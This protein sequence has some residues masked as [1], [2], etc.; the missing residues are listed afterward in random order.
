MRKVQ[1]NRADEERDTGNLNKRIEEKLQKESQEFAKKKN[2]EK[3][4]RYGRVR[5]REK[6]IR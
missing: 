5:E 3:C 2:L 4:R 6:G 1:T